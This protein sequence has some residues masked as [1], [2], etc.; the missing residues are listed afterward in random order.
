M[1]IGGGDTADKGD[2]KEDENTFERSSK[3]ESNSSLDLEDEEDLEYG[4]E[5]EN[6]QFDNELMVNKTHNHGMARLDL[7]L[8][9][10][11][12]RTRSAPKI[13]ITEEENADEYFINIDRK[14]LRRTNSDFQLFRQKRRKMRNKGTKKG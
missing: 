12:Y 13:N 2:E 6:D 11:K 5:D 9:E 7:G 10:G 14:K 1:V 8:L 3:N 4:S